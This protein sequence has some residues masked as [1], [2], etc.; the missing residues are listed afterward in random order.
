MKLYRA[1]SAAEYK[2]FKTDQ[3]FR[4]AENTIEGKQF[5]K[6]Q[7]AVLEYVEAAV[8]RGYAP[9]HYKYLLTITVENQCFDLINYESQIL[10]GHE[11]ITIQEEDLPAFNNCFT[12]E[13]VQN[14]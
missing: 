12:F 3:N 7:N 5:F 10:D 4:T 9:P 6:S 1:V 13:E 8:K 14:V 2:D 11:A